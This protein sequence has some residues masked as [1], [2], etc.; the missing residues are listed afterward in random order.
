M[1][2]NTTQSQNKRQDTKY[3]F[4]TKLHKLCNRIICWK[5]KPVTSTTKIIWKATEETFSKS[6]SQW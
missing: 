2:T 3:S 4:N 5:K 1:K 6:Y